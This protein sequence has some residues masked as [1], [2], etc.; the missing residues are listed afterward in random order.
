MT[1]IVGCKYKNSITLVGDTVLTYEGRN[2]NII[3]V[4]Q[5]STF[6]ERQIQE[7][8][9]VVQEA[10]IKI[11]KINKQCIAG[12]AGLS[13]IAEDFFI[14]LRRL[15]NKDKNSSFERERFTS[16]L[17]ELVNDID[18]D[19]KLEVAFIFGFINS[20]KEAV[21][22]SYNNDGTGNFKEHNDIVQIGSLTE[23]EMYS[24]LTDIFTKVMTNYGLEGS[25]IQCVISS[26]VQS[27]GI[28]DNILEKYGVGGTLLNMRLTTEKVE[29]QENTIFILYESIKNNYLIN[30]V[31]Y[32]GMYLLADPKGDISCLANTFNTF[33]KTI[34]NIKDKSK[35]LIKNAAYTKV[36]VLSV[37]NRNIVLIDRNRFKDKREYFDFKFSKGLN[38][39][40]V[41]C[42]KLKILIERTV[43]A[44]WSFS[45][46][47]D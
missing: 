33:D 3:D 47:D 21:L 9:K 4:K 35:D 12:F 24:N 10:G 23:V 22:M 5:S 20:Q 36:V 43:G 15:L 28:H 37:I 18:D 38:V 46:V 17:Q 14:N 31:Y 29:Y 45:K 26:F 19:K 41:V 8:N 13:K 27:Y 30:L 32:E 11:F 40:A 2:M 25:L 44:D 1:Y 34:L 7:P 39:D 16:I 6:L 42:E